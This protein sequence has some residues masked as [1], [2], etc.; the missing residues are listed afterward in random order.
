MVKICLDDHCF[1]LSPHL[2]LLEGLEAEG[3]EWPNRVAVA[4]VRPVW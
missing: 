2:S 4:N 1:E 3:M